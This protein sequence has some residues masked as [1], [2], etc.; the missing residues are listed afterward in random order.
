MGEALLHD[1][2]LLLHPTDFLPALKVVAGVD[3][4]WGRPAPML[5]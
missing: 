1:V 4:S 2:D 5:N 3:N